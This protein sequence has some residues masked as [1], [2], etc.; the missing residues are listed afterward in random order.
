AP[1][2]TPSQGASTGGTPFVLFGQNFPSDALIKIG[3]HLATNV[4]VASSTGI[5]A[6]TPAN[7]KN[8][9]VDVALYSA[10]TNWLALA[11]DA[12]SYG[13]R[14]LGVLPNTGNNNG[15]DTIQ[16]FGYGF[17]SDPGALTVKIAGSNAVV[18]SV[19]NL[20][21]LSPSLGLDVTYPFS[22]E[23]ITLQTPPGLPGTADIMVTA[24]SGSASS[25]RAFQ[26]LHSAQSYS[27]PGFYRFLTYDQKRQ[28]VYLSNIDHVD[29]FDL[30]SSA[31]LAPIQPPGGPP[32]NA[33]LRG[34]AMTGG[35]TQL[36]VADF[37]A[38][39]VYQ[40]N[41]DNGSGTITHVGGVT[42]F[43]SSGPSLV[44]ATSI[45]TVFVGL[46]GVGSAGA[47]CPSCLAQMNV[48]V[49]PPT[50]QPVPQPEVSAIVGAPLLH[51]NSAGDHVFLAFASGAGG[52]LATW[53][54]AAPN[55]FLVSPVGVSVNDIAPA[56]DGNVFA[57]QS[58]SSTEVRNSAML[59]TAVP[60]A[61]ELTQIPGRQPVPGLAVHP[62]GALI[63]QPFLTGVAGA[64]GVKGGVDIVDAHSGELRLRIVLPQQLMTDV[65]ALHGGFLAI[66]E[67]GQR[68]FAITT[69]DGSPQQASLSVVQLAAVPLGIGSVTPANIA[70]AGGTSV[71][72][73]GSGF[74]AGVKVTIGGKTATATLIDM[75]TLTVSAPALAAGSQQL[76]ITNANGETVSLDG[77]VSAN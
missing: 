40:F 62:S 45:Q 9:T 43:A 63:Y 4:N 57:L 22:L 55:Q 8:E 70:V 49:S 17:G 54:A 37:G 18:Q 76:V 30:S 71:N 77:A 32:P 23:R 11:P 6:T 21:G 14:I 53:N 20:P 52:Q 36:L 41:P 64:P 46:S 7:A 42:G 58:N 73:R 27:K 75:N 72:I 16:I 5:Q 34:L 61:A 19:D 24:S 69:L 67:S 56:A 1:A 44:A 33:G 12:F 31:F 26:Y 15:G 28:R 60:A 38:Q 3:T 47:A 51:G 59:L 35:G 66:D 25:T 2:I 50:V 68:L 10:A 48:A 74:L 13:P 65:D 39:S 29:V